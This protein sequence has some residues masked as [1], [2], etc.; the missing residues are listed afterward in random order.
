MG[1][2]V[3]FFGKTKLGGLGVVRNWSTNVD[4]LEL[5]VVGAS[6]RRFVGDRDDV[7]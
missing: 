5:W 6:D 7:R 2:G 3:F 4:G 1:V